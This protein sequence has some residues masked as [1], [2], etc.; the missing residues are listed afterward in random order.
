MAEPPTDVLVAGY[1]SIGTATRDFDRLL[2]RVK[3]KKVVIEGVILVTHDKHGDV[4]VKQTGDHLG[5]TGVKWGAGVGLAVGLFAPPMLVSTAVTGA[6][7][8]GLVGK[9]VDQPRRDGDSRQDR[10]EPAAG[11]G[12]DH[13]GVRRRPAPRG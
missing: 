10:R 3:A 4:S 5:R 9:F 11:V 6:V 2:T 12:G 1:R 13:R 8:G 7:A